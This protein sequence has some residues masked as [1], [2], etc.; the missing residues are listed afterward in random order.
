MTVHRDI[1]AKVKLTLDSLHA[2]C[3]S[4]VCDYQNDVKELEKAR[5]TVDRKLELLRKLDRGVY[6]REEFKVIRKQFVI[7]TNKKGVTEF[8]R[9]L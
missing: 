7:F 9:G 6:E 8:G 1:T 5:V 2:S 4:L 3:Y